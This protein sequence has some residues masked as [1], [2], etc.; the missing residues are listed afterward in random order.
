MGLLSSS[1]PSGMVMWGSM[2]ALFGPKAK[3]FVVGTEI[4]C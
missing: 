2:N 4:P 3:R 1:A